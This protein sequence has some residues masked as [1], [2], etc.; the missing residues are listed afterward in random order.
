VVVASRRAACSSARLTTAANL[1]EYC[2]F[3]GGTYW[4]DLRIAHGVKQPHG[5]KVWCL[6]NEMDA[7]WQIG[8]KTAD[9]YG[10]LAA[11]AAKAMRR[12]DPSIELVACGSSNSMMPTFAAWEA[13]VLEHTYEQVDYLSLHH[14]YEDVEGDPGS[15]L[16]SSVS[17]D[18]F[19]NSV[20]A[21]C[22]YVKARLRSGKRVD[23]AFDEWNVWERTRFRAGPQWPWSRAPRL[24]EDVYSVADAVVVGTLLIT[25]LRH[26]DRIKIA[27]QAQLVNAIGLIMTEPS[28][29]AWR[30]TIFYPFAHASRW[31]RGTVLRL[32]PASPMYE[33]AAYGA[34][35][36][37][38]AT[39]TMDEGEQAL[40]IF[41]VNRDQ[42]EPLAIT[43]DLHALPGY[44]VA[45]HLVLTDDDIN[46]SNTL[47]EPNRVRPQVHA[48]TG[49]A[50]GSLHTTLPPLSWNVITLRQQT[51]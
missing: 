12:V 23:L 45:Q 39:A 32:E 43:G 3:P 41:A 42:R 21:T 20:V 13:Q 40:T 49:V 25:L 6:G 18:R 35:P 44:Q 16:A 8:H 1:V 2:N 28:G 47:E 17:M 9:E 7:P 38:E 11:E 19:I 27:C 4:S 10:R 50:G 46:A 15:F 31:G 30:Q 26:A 24:I 48:G 36:V 22:D 33:S 29:P 5:V 14:Y 37:L 51:E 34:V